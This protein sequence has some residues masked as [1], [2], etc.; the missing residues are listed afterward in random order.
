MFILNFS[1]ISSLFLA[2]L[3]Y[4]VF[5]LSILLY[6]IPSLSN[7]KKFYSFKNK[8]SFFYVSGSSFFFIFF[9]FFL[10]FFIFLSIWSFPSTS[11]WF[12]H[13]VIFSFSHKMNY[14]VLFVF[15]FILYTQ[16][17]NVYFS[18]KEIFDFFIAKINFFIWIVLIFYTNNL[19][20]TIFIVEI[21][22]TLIFLILITSTFSTTYFFNNLNLNLYNYLANSFP[23]FFNQTVLFFF[24]TSL[25][26]SLNLFLSI[27]FFYLKFFSF[28]WF[29]LEKIFLYIITISSVKDIIFLFFT[30]FNFLF[31]IFLKCGLVPFYAWK[32]TFF[33]GSPLNFLYIYICFFYFFIFL[34]FIKFL[35][36]NFSEVFFFFI[37][38]NFLTLLL[39]I[40]VLLAILSET[41]YLKTFFAMSSILNTLFVFLA[42]S[43]TNLVDFFFIL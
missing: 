12:G 9:Y 26:A 40:T 43:T 19:F 10:F 23:F 3:F 13:L 2:S 7:F 21:L 1:T 30:W 22:S 18:S 15:S 14:F 35:I 25:L 38:I 17:L 6:L 5:L 4:F 20:S 37:I 32:P 31:C 29:F 34:F 28:E 39:G 16:I 27:L 41:F 11:L 33:K 8:N 42:F 36:I 24:W